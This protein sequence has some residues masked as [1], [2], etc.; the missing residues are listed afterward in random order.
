MSHPEFG[1]SVRHD[2]TGPTSQD[3]SSVSSNLALEEAPRHDGAPA[4]RG[5][6]PERNSSC[7]AAGVLV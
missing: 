6:G 4:F 5:L 7:R 2:P 1:A 3:G